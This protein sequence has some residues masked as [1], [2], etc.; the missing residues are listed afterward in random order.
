[1]EGKRCAREQYNRAKKTSSG[2]VCGCLSGVGEKRKKRDEGLFSNNHDHFPSAHYV[3]G[4]GFALCVCYLTE[5]LQLLRNGIFWPFY[6]RGIVG[7]ERFIMFPRP[8]NR[9]SMI[10][11][12]Q[13]TGNS[14]VP[15]CQLLALLL[16]IV[17]DS[18]LPRRM[19]GRGKGPQEN[20][21]RKYSTSV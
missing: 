8:Q 2:L 16:L 17:L 5:S 10:Q 21:I 20:E 12:G 1:M 14:V 3:S 13:V 11:V 6:G 18:W 4:A 19:L 9:N 7:L 15:Q